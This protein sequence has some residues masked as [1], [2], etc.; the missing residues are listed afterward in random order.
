M[1]AKPGKDRQLMSLVARKQKDMAK[2][3]S[4]RRAVGDGHP[5]A[6]AMKRRL[7]VNLTYVHA[8]KTPDSGN[9][10]CFCEAIQD[11]SPAK[12]ADHDQPAQR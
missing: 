3:A 12:H 2:T 9:K 10:A 8:P 6:K 1:P 11:R 4:N 7:S 5:C